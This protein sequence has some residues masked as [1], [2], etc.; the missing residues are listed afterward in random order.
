ML[1]SLN[2][3]ISGLRAHQNMLDVTGNNIAN[4]NTTGFKSSRTQFQ[5]TLSQLV[6]AG[7]APDQQVGGANPAQIGLGVTTAAITTQFTQGAAQT[8]G[9]PT[10]LMIDG[11]GFFVVE[12]GGQAYYTRNGGFTFDGAGRLVNASGDLVQ[13]WTATDGVVNTS[14]PLGNLTIPVG[15]V[16]PPRATTGVTFGGNLPSDAADGTELVRDVEV[17]DAAGRASKLSLVFA[18][19]G[20]GWSVSARDGATGA[21]V[22]GPQA[23][24][25][26]GGALTGG[27]SLAVGGV[28][29]GLDGL[30][31]YAGLSNVAVASKDGG[32][33]GSLTSYSVSGD[34]SIVG[35]YS[36]GRTEVLGQVALATFTNAGGLEKAG[37]S[38]FAATQYS[39]D[40]LVG[41]AGDPGLG[42]ITAGALEMSNVDLSQE[43]TNLIVSQRGFQAN[44][45]VITT[46]DEVLTELVNLKR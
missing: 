25:F 12:R 3:G 6:A 17:F 41:A 14:S 27:G 36:N 37:D 38:L 20:G 21:T 44:S 1:R 24:T 45:R 28:T 34:G 11:D 40:L 4:V 29:V 26:T 7:V 13:G 10:D 46:S 9:V 43:F 35:R 31:S 42:S 39:G 33:A 23:L 8:T 15:D 16:I 22:A 32:A 2:T 18:A 30:T 19:A 5:D